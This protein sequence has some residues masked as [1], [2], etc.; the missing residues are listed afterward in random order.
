[1]DH[2]ASA[3]GITFQL[4]MI[5]DA[6]GAV[7][8]DSITFVPEV[9]PA[10]FHHDFVETVA[11]YKFKPANVEGCAVSGVATVSVGYERRR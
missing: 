3:Y 1:M 6:S 4:R 8:K 7:V 9:T 11:A 5:V 10:T 2:P